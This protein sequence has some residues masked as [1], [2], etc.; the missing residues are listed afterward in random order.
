MKGGREQRSGKLED[1]NAFGSKL[2]WTLIETQF[3]KP[4]EHWELSQQGLQVNGFG[5]GRGVLE[6]TEENTMSEI[7]VTP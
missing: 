2:L 6:L 5:E 4:R 1:R 7:P 3:R